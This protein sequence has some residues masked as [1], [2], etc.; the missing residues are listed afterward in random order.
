VR[1]YGAAWYH[2]PELWGTSDGIVPWREFWAWFQAIGAGRAWDRM[3]RARAIGMTQGEP[4][5]VRQAWQDD[6]RE[7]FG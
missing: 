7:A 2:N 4:A 3:D 5:K 6:H 1:W